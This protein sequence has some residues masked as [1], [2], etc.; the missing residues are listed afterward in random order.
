MNNKFLI[1]L[2]LVISLGFGIYFVAI[3]KTAEQLGPVFGAA[4]AQVIGEIDTSKWTSFNTR[5]MASCIKGDDS[6]IDSAETVAGAT[7]PSVDE[8]D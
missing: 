8:E 2:V 1:R 3:P 6:W 7:T 4:N 5:L